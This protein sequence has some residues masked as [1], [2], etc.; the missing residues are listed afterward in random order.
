VR[1]CDVLAKQLHAQQLQIP[2]RHAS[3]VDTLL[4]RLA[5]QHAD[6]QVEML[7]DMRSARYD[8]LICMLVE[9]AS[10]PTFRIARDDKLGLPADEIGVRLVRRQWQS[11]ERAANS[12]GPTPSQESLHDIRILAKRCRYAADA[13]VPIAGKPAKRFAAAIAE[14]TG[15]LGDHHDA[16][17]AQAWL[18]GAAD[19]LPSTAACVD[20]L[21]SIQQSERNRI[22]DDWSMTWSRLTARKRSRQRGKKSATSP[23]SWLEPS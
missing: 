6:A 10:R 17:I 7:A 12:A 5:T 21:V 13:L 16:A 1:E 4:E 3:A 22:E 11:L 20:A 8:N 23:L 15:M 14:L 19:A 9:A 18:I 2:K